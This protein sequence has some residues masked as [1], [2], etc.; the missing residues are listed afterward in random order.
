MLDCVS[1]PT[2]PAS[3]VSLSWNTAC[4]LHFTEHISLVIFQT[5]SNIYII[6]TLTYAFRQHSCHT[7]SSGRGTGSLNVHYFHGWTS[8]RQ[9]VPRQKWFTNQSNNS[10]ND[11]N[12]NTNNNDNNDN[13]IDNNNGN[14]NNNT[15]NT[16]TT[17][18]TLMPMTTATIT[19]I[20]TIVMMKIMLI[21]IILMMMM[22]VI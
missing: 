12:N 11:N 14:G 4:V 21:T 22:M 18:I 9:T 13:D 5:K 20:I 1:P 16:D 15:D 7:D 17:P 19:I 10:D 2:K 3:N 8:Q 6:A